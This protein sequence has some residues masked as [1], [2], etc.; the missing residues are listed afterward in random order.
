MSNE[1][2]IEW[3]THE[4]LKESWIKIKWQNSMKVELKINEILWKMNKSLMEHNWKKN[5]NFGKMN[6]KY[7]KSKNEVGLKNCMKIK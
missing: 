4:N 1:Y 3:K 6:K 7:M 5:Q 2:K